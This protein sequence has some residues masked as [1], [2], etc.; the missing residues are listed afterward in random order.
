MTNRS[1]KKLIISVIILGIVLAI[2]LFSVKSL[3][4][5]KV[6]LRVAEAQ[7][8]KYLGLD[9]HAASARVSWNGR[10]ELMAVEL[11]AGAQTFL[12]TDTVN[13][14]F[15][16]LDL[17]RGKVTVASI[18]LKNPK[19]VLNDQ[20]VKAL[21]ALFHQKRTSTQTFPVTF[22]NGQFSY[23]ALN[24]KK[25][26]FTQTSGKFTLLPDGI[27][28]QLKLQDPQEGQYD[29]SGTVAGDALNM[30]GKM[31]NIALSE[32]V[33]PFG[34]NPI[35]ELQG[36]I[37]GSFDVTGK[38]KQLSIRTNF[39][40]SA[41]FFKGNA[42]VRATLEP[43]MGGAL[44]KGELT[45]D[46][47]QIEGIGAFKG[48]SV[49]FST[50]S[51]GLVFQNGTIEFPSGVIQFSGA[52]RKDY[53]VAVH[54]K[55]DS[56]NPFSLPNF[57]GWG[58]RGLPGTL[59]GE[60][61]GVFPRLSFTT[62][63]YFPSMQIGQSQLK[64]LALAVKARLSSQNATIDRFAL[65]SPQGNLDLT[66]ALQWDNNHN[67]SLRFQRAD[68]RQWA[69]LFHL[70][71]NL[72]PLQMLVSGS[73]AYEKSSRTWK[74]NVESGSGM[75][76]GEA[77][78]RFSGQFSY[79]EKQPVVFLGAFQMQ[80]KTAQVAGTWKNGAGDFKL[81]AIGFPMERIPFLRSP[82]SGFHGLASIH[83]KFSTRSGSRNQ[84]NFSL[85]SASYQGKPLPPM[86]GVVSIQQDVIYFDSLR[87]TQTSPPVNITGQYN[88][89]S[90]FMRMAASL[91]GQ[92]S[93]KILSFIDFP[94]KAGQALH[95]ALEIS[96]TYPNISI[97][98]QGITPSLSMT[99][100]INLARK[101]VQLHSILNGE[102]LADL[103]RMAGESVG[104]TR[105]NL[106]GN[107]TLSGSVSGMEMR[108]TGHGKNLSFS[109]MDLGEADL[110]LERT[111]SGNLSVRADNLDASR[112][113][114]LQQA[115]PGLSGN[116]QI[117]A[118]IMGSRI[119]SFNFQLENGQWQG[120]SFP[121]FRGTLAVEGSITKFSSLNIG[122]ISPPLSAT[123]EVNSQ[124]H[125]YRFGANLD[126]QRIADLMSIG[127]LQGHD[128]DAHLY[129][130]MSVSGD[131]GTRSIRFAGT[132]KGLKFRGISMGN[133]HLDLMAQSDASKHYDVR[134][135]ASNIPAESVSLL[136][137]HYSG[138]TGNVTIKASFN[139]SNTNQ[140]A[141]DFSLT[142]ASRAGRE[143]P[144]LVGQSRWNAPILEFSSL[145]APKFSPPLV[146]TGSYNS[147]T[148]AL[149]LSGHLEGQALS[150][151][152]ALAGVSS[153]ESANGNMT[154]P[155]TMQGP[156]DSPRLDFHGQISNL[157]YKGLHL[158]QGT[159]DVTATSNALDGELRLDNPAT[160]APTNSLVTSVIQQIIPQVGDIYQSIVP[161]VVLLGVK[162]H[163]TPKH[164]QFTPDF[165]QV[166][167]QRKLKNKPAPAQSNPTPNSPIPSNPVTD[168][169]NQILNPRH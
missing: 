103:S 118:S 12:S 129:G 134:V 33:T 60:A 50:P 139:T 162:I 76:A 59:Q 70:Q 97:S 111:A 113:S 102:S 163:G 66:G 154:G 104:T 93:E 122:G 41:G 119:S 127:G 155:L 27:P 36:K 7:L 153:D 79:Q 46:N 152:L 81:D 16:W 126:G 123:G 143:F 144:E 82:V 158:G 62:Q 108:F 29:F 135:K 32:I 4:Q 136:A 43:T 35:P 45:S 14:G 39:T 5:S 53:S 164:P 49:G 11:K 30:Q 24:G 54:Y 61:V 34:I 84:I 121:L 115:F 109:G 159:L 117:H 21:S 107:L 26:I 19:L 90:K 42:A 98:Y 3:V 120:K 101:E 145:S 38:L 58:I 168:I 114:V 132:G 146:L 138:I 110:T 147:D 2:G 67:L 52:I 156:S 55:S 44:I 20:S 137:R 85:P 96:G 23:T 1:S 150:E 73:T 17:L 166:A 80:G 142:E 48:F 88:L 140:A 47:G 83:A 157:V 57:S 78:D 92:N 31:K 9:T 75:I 165:K 63:G 51:E 148:R 91:N 13:L 72:S 99:G 116:L 106:Y 69:S 89:K 131:S 124:T 161:D 128:L 133:G 71:N 169:L 112:I 10:F 141:L 6:N 94:A 37:S 100:T 40:E 125:Q 22:S 160:L 15:H 65:K 64:N 74:G 87:L 86:E 105:G 149:S 167:V 77:F 130:P 28:F 25:I 8:S 68:V 95:G 18:R 151:L 56:F